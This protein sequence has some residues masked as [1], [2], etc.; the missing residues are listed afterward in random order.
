M[1]NG[2]K[3]F[4]SGEKVQINYGSTVI[5]V[6]VTFEERKRLT[7]TVE[8]DKSVH[9][10]APLG[11][12]LEE[13]GRYLKKRAG[14]IVRQLDH[15]EQFHPMLPERQYVSGES[16]FYLGRQYRLKVSKGSSTKVKLIGKFF[17][18]EVLNPEN[19]ESVKKVMQKWYKEHAKLLL[20]RRINNYLKYFS[21]LG[22]NEP[23]IFFRRMKKRWGSYSVNGNILLNT[24]LVKAPT[25]CIDYVIVHELCHLLYP[26]HDKRFYHLLEKI[27]PD[28]ESRKSRL[29]KVII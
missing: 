10:K 15:F 13:V 27:L 6:L 14:W 29:E 19:R 1:G 9:A 16:H 20:I 2:N 23:R 21:K 25:H 5:E 4:V 11:R 22:C 7:I 8:P 17:Y 18:V 26:R 24:E 28:W 3:P 12:S